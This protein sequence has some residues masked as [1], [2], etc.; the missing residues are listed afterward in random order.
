MKIEA[1]NQTV[2]VQDFQTTRRALSPA[3]DFD[4]ADVKAG[5]RLHSALRDTPDLRA[6]A[7]ARGKALIADPNYPSM[8][9]VKAM[10]KVL[11]A[12]LA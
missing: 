9:Q 7:V 4:L 3:T 11:A 2:P 12:R 1:S 5:R 10:A 8:A 6:D